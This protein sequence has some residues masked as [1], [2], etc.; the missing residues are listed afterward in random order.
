MLEGFQSQPP[1]F[2]GGQEWKAAPGTVRRVALARW[3]TS[4]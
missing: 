3:M 2:L 4:P 1:T